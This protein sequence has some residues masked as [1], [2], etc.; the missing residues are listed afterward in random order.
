VTGA[1]FSPDGKWLAV[2]GSR[3]KCLLRVGTWEERPL[4]LGWPTAFSAD[5]SIL[6][7]VSDAGEI[8]LLAPESLRELARLMEPNQERPSSL[9]FTPDG[10]K[11]LVSSD[12]GR[13]LHI[14]DLRSL[15]I[16]LAELGLDWDLPPLSPAPPPS[17]EPLQV[18][19][20]LG[21]FRQL[22]EATALV[23]QAARHVHAKKHAD[24]LAAL[25]RAVAVAPRHAEAHNNLSWMLLTGLQERRDAALA[26]VEA[27]KAVELEPERALF[28]NTLGVALYRNGKFADAVPVLEWSLRAQK[29]QADSFDLFFLALCHH[30]LGDAAKAKEYRERAVVWFA[31]HKDRLP[32]GWVEELTAFQAEAA[33]VCAQATNRETK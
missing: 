4:H 13:A 2:G 5:S 12:D 22:T 30:R 26:L 25:R 16:Q 20:D 11:L 9:A 8:R 24:A 27:R 23:Q 28:Q 18:Q 7:V 19:I 15:R 6:A 33:S 17:P 10:G 32:A 3:G 1:L 29:G 21:D 14:W 31:Q